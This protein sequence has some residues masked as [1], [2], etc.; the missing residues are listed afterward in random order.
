MS[1]ADQA[2]GYTKAHEVHHPGASISTRWLPH[3]NRI[4]NDLIVDI[5][6][7][8]EGKTIAVLV[9]TGKS[10]I[11]KNISRTKLAGFDEVRVIPSHHRQ[12][13]L[14]TKHFE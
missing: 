1:C 10:H 14:N 13:I 5:C 4:S 2:Q 7:Q 9:E 8:K 12:P 6:A 3:Y 11:Q